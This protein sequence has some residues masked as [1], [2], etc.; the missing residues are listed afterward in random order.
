[1]FVT[2]KK[3]IPSIEKDYK[4]GGF[5]YNLTVINYES[6]HK[7]KSDFDVVICDECHCLG[8]YPKKSNRVKNI[9]LKTRNKPIVFLSATPS[10]ESW[11]QLYHQFFI[12]S[13]SPFKAFTSFYK[14]AHE[15]VNIRKKFIYNREVNDYSQADKR[16]IW[17]RIKHLFITFTQKEAGFAQEVNEHVL[18][19]ELPDRIKEITKS[20]KKDN[21]YKDNEL[22]IIADTAVKVM[23]KIHQLASGTVIDE[24]GYQIIDTFK[25]DYLKTFIGNK[26]AA[27]F[28][29]FKSEFEMLKVAFPTWTDNA[30]DFQSSDNAIFLGQFQSAREGIRLD[31]AEFIIF[32]SIDFSYLSYEQAKNRIAS[33]ER[34]NEA[35]LYWLFAKGS[36]ENYIYKAVMSKQ[37]YT[38]SYFKK[39]VENGRI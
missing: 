2:K 27:I 3:A 37:N 4:A 19:I 6:V 38:V 20:L 9:M 30:F 12:S 18:S 21:I 24:N 25:A 23:Q 10:P 34:E 36:I 11:S 22:F 29:K 31:S 39:D 35:K 26:K 1:L 14:F 15:F 16:A 28:Y 32:F 13:Y 8:Q 7:V 17:E 5:K 33:F